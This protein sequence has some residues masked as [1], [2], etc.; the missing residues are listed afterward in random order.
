[1]EVWLQL[2]R[3]PEPDIVVTPSPFD[4]PSWIINE[5]GSPHGGEGSP[6]VPPQPVPHYDPLQDPLVGPMLLAEIRRELAQRD[7]QGLEP[8]MR[9]PIAGVPCANPCVSVNDRSRFQNPGFSGSPTGGIGSVKTTLLNVLLLL[10]ELVDASA[11]FGDALSF[12]ATNWIRNLLETNYVVNKYSGAYGAGKYMGYVLGG[13]G[14]GLRGAAAFGRTRPGNSLLNSNPYIRIG[15]GRMPANG[16]FP[17]SPNAPR[18][19]IGR[20]PGN[21]HIDLRVRGLD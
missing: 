20:G 2:V 10:Q 18:L 8:G 6:P 21:P 4:D 12:G 19:S 1:M 15:P 13:T 16:P 7:R 5:P 11:G 3:G 14:I 17:A 9:P